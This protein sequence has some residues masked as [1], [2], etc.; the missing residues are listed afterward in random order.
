[1]IYAII[2]SLNFI[3]FIW[4][5]TD[6]FQ[7]LYFL[8]KS[9]VVLC[10]NFWD[11]TILGEKLFSENYERFCVFS[12]IRSFVASEANTILCRKFRSD[13]QRAGV[14][15]F[16]THIRIV[17]S[18]HPSLK[19]PRN[20]VLFLGKYRMYEMQMLFLAANVCSDRISLETSASF[21]KIQRLS[22]INHHKVR[23][24]FAFSP[25]FATWVLFITEIHC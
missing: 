21:A 11:G 18:F 10:G 1:M 9:T 5:T 13:R 22:C 8:R 23:S 4:K 3:R 15:N 6:R 19:F 7:P 2:H 17:C 14:W 20:A 16:T 12:E 25:F 24:G